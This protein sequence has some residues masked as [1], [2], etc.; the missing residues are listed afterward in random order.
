MAGDGVG[1]AGSHQQSVWFPEGVVFAVFRP[2]LS[3][4]AL[5]RHF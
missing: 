2:C 5:H 1:G 4:V 3:L